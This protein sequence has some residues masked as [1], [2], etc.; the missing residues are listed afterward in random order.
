MK[1]IKIDT[2]EIFY[3]GKGYLAHNAWTIA[4]LHLIQ[5]EFIG[6]FT[7]SAGREEGVQ[8]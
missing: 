5:S 4:T 6:N 8:W 2:Q 7:E 3:T 1:K